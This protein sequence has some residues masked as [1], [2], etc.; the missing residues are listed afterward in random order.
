MRQNPNCDGAHCRSETGEVRVYPL[1]SGGNLIL[2]LAC[3][4]HENRYRYERAHDGLGDPKNWPQEDWN[5]AEV[6]GEPS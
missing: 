1:G 2:C 5:K 6:Y 4:A 3:W